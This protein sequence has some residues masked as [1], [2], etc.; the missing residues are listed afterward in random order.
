MKQ[1]VTN[2][3]YYNEYMCS[4]WSVNSKTLQAYGVT[5]TYDTTSYQTLSGVT[6]TFVT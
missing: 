1:D 4:S 6:Y 5:A 3:S 2:W